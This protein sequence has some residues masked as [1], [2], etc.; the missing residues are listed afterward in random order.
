MSSDCAELYGAPA[1][2]L[3]Y[4]ISELLVSEFPVSRPNVNPAVPVSLVIW[5]ST[6]PDFLTW[7]SFTG[8]WVVPTPSF[9]ANTVDDAPTY[10][11]STFPVK[12]DMLWL[13]VFSCS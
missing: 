12:V 13:I 2:C 6:S 10:D 8:A 11:A 4:L 1:D 9:V 7:I 5:T 3:P